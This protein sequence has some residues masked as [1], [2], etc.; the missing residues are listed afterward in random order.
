[1]DGYEMDSNKEHGDGRPD[2]LLC[3]FHPQ[4][5]AIIIEVK[6]A[7]KY[8]QMEEMCDA[9]LSQIEE[10]RYDEELLEEGYQK[11]LKYGFCFCKK[12]CLVKRKEE[13][14]K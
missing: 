12:S 5:P 2:I 11:I 3:P 10:R 14:K 8:A 6:C 1:M 13:S 4:H 9:A 7:A